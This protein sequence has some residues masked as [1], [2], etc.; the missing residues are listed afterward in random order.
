MRVSSLL[1]EFADPDFPLDFPSGPER[2]ELERWH[3]PPAGHH[4]G[5]RRAGLLKG[6]GHGMGVLFDTRS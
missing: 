3:P 5:R 2:R 4:G 6:L 1:Q